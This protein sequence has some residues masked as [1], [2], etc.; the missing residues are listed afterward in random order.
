MRTIKHFLMVATL[1]FSTWNI[2]AQER[3][4]NVADVA[5][6][7]QQ[8]PTAYPTRD[9]RT[10][11]ALDGKPGDG[12]TPVYSKANPVN[13][14]GELLMVRGTNDTTGV[15]R[16]ADNDHLGIGSAFLGIIAGSREGILSSIYEPAWD[17]SVDP[18]R[19]DW[20]WFH[21]HNWPRFGT[22]KFNDPTTYQQ[23]GTA[24]AGM[25]FINGGGEGD[26]DDAGRY[27]AVKMIPSSGGY[28]GGHFVNVKVG[29]IDLVAGKVLP[30]LVDGNPNA[31]DVTPDGKWLAML[32]HAAALAE[33][34]RFYSIA[35]LA[36]GDVTAPVIAQ[37]AQKMHADWGVPYRSVGHNGFGRDRAGKV[38]W[39]GQDNINDDI[40]KMDPA[41][42]IPIRL[43][44]LYELTASAPP[45]SPGQ[46]IAR[47]G[48]PG[49]AV[50]ST[51]NVADPSIGLLDLETGARIVKG[52]M[53]LKAASGSGGWFFSE[54]YAASDAAG[55]WA[56]YGANADGGDNLECFR[57]AL[58][59]EAPTPTPTP[60][61]AP[62][63]SPTPTPIPA[64]VE[65]A[66]RFPTGYVIRARYRYRETDKPRLMT[67]SGGDLYPTAEG[68]RAAAAMLP[69]TYSEAQVVA[70]P[71][72]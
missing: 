36:R 20:I 53:R 4:T 61:P 11:A 55:A 57:M 32:P 40:F 70:V 23:R 59:G 34:N 52:S 2:Q 65:P 16:L 60:T 45:V 13:S 33:G 29:V 14:T 26:L 54:G 44:S 51:Y 50:Y 17:R 67:K 37:T 49:F 35:D 28:V 46:H 48:P 66:Y 30:G 25:H 21:D 71:G 18:A 43:C 72:E 38:W 8:N 3:I 6:Y 47:Q 10:M 5:A 68:A 12:W 15:Y 9:G 62:T 1:I 58:T 31:I 56:Y 24:P 22:Q 64:T 27:M 41:N 42:G 7:Y 63:P 69:S 19:A 39:I